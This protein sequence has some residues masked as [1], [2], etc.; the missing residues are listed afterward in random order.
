MTAFSRP[1]IAV[2]TALASIM[3]LSAAANAFPAAKPADTKSNLIQVNDRYDRDGRRYHRHYHEG[4]N[5]VHAPFT[6]VQ[7]GRRTVV[8][9]PFVHVYSGRHGRTHVVAPFVN[10]WD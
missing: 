2:T 8:D 3:A 5:V 9:A 4:R 10:Y 1:L 6:R 7:S